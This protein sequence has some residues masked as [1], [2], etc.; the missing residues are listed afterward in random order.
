M[1]S[2]AVLN[3]QLLRSWRLDLGLTSDIWSSRQHCCRSVLDNTMSEFSGRDLV[4]RHLL[5]ALGGKAQGISSGEAG[6]FQV[7]KSWSESDLPMLA[8]GRRGLKP[9]RGRWAGSAMTL[10]L[11]AS[12]STSTDTDTDT[13]TEP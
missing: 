13:D 7:K 2:G 8:C 11:G 6:V 3:V 5:D 1:I 12:T 10:A 9:G 4:R